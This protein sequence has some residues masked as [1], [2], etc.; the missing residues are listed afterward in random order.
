MSTA[1][2]LQNITIEFHLIARTCSLLW[3]LNSIEKLTFDIYNG[4]NKDIYAPL[5]LAVY[6]E[7][8]KVNRSQ[9][10][11]LYYSGKGA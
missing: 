1:D 3:L 2:K 10:L 6:K 7:V 11:K 4:V 8:L 9:E 5:Q